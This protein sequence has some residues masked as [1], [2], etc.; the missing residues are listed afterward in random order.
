MIPSALQVLGMESAASCELIYR[1]GLFEADVAAH[2]LTRKGVRV[3]IQNKAFC[4]LVLLLKNP[5]KTITREELHRALWPEGTYVDFDTGLNV[6]LK[7]LRAAI[8]DDSDNPR[9]IETVPRRG[10]RFIA[11]VS[12]DQ[13]EPFSDPAHPTTVLSSDLSHPARR[14][15]L[16][17][18]Y[19]VVGPALV[20]VGSGWY[21]LR[22]RSVVDAAPKIIAVLPF[23]N[24][25][26]GPD[27][28]YL[29][30]AIPNDL[31]TDLT[32]TQSIAVRPFSSTSRYGTQAKDPVAVGKE[33]GVTHI[34]GGG[35]FRDQKTLRVNLEL[36]DVAHNQTVWSDEVTV[37]PQELVTLHDKLEVSTSQGL[38]AAM[39]ITNATANQIPKPN[40]EEAFDLF[41]HSLGYPLD[42]GPN[43]M[44]IKALEDSVALDSGYAPAWDQLSWRYYIDERYGNGGAGAAAK[45]A[46]AY[47]RQRELDPNA[48]PISTT[49]RTEQGDLN[50]AYD[51]AA[52]FLGRR[53]DSSMAHFWMSYVLR[54]AGLLD[55]AGK[56][57][58]VALALDPGFS[59]LRS[60]ATTFGLAG[61]YGHA[62]KYI[63]VDEGSGFAALSR[64]EI[65]L[66]TRD[67]TAALAEAS[68]TARLGYRNVNAELARVYLSHPSGANLARAVAEV[69][70]DPVS[71][72]D[73]ELLYRNAEALAFCGLPDAALRQLGKAIKGKYCSYPAMDNDPLFD[74]L[75]QRSEFAELR[76]AGM[77]CQ[78]N[79]LNHRKHVDASLAGK[80]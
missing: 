37:A 38:L 47:E 55:E 17:L 5:G 24:E 3:R 63:K 25:G 12:V 48:P 9:F 33:L 74:S 58:D 26:A 77:Q 52:E 6:V 76:Q 67:T 62:E 28:D 71:A 18:K 69:E 49:L 45:A 59:V 2:T 1:F 27:F 42:P 44:A 66:R 70:A 46:Q 20:F 53:P 72:R 50:G 34:L 43:L 13:R 39:K 23:S 79:F 40:N 21:L 10:Y 19:A 41:L 54:Y 36:I 11:P 75:R 78:L 80:R 51:Q 35:F 7:K 14:I 73:P 4:V 8:D 56:Q 31:V 65:A 64:M 16:W 22:H 32:Y 29:R 15:K 60:C 68:S 61:D 30:Y 57:C